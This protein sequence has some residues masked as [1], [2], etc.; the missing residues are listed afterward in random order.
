M[1]P[2]TRED[3]IE[4]SKIFKEPPMTKHL[5]PRIWVSSNDNYYGL[6]QVDAKSNVEKIA[7]G[8]SRYDW[9]M[10]S[11]ADP[12]KAIGPDYRE[13]F[14]H[15]ATASFAKHFQEAREI[16]GNNEV[17]L[18]RRTVLVAELL[19]RLYASI[20]ERHKQFGRLEAI[21]DIVG[22]RPGE[23]IEVTVKNLA[24]TECRLRLELMDE[25]REKLRLKMEIGH[26]VAAMSRELRNLRASNKAFVAANEEQAKNIRRL[27][28]MNTNQAATIRAVMDN[29]DKFR[30]ETR[31]IRIEDYVKEMSE[32]SVGFQTTIQ[33]LL[34]EN[35]RLCT[36]HESTERK[37]RALKTALGTHGCDNSL[38]EFER[39]KKNAFC[40][41]VVEDIDAIRKALGINTISDAVVAINELKS[42]Q[43]GPATN[44]LIDRIRKATDST[45]FIL[46]V[47][48][49]EALAASDAAIRSI[50]L[51]TVGI[52]Q[53]TSDTTEGL[54]LAMRK[55]VE[56]QVA[57][58]DAI[59]NRLGCATESH[60]AT[61]RK[62]EDLK[63]NQCDWKWGDT[64]LR[65]KS[66]VG[67]EKFA[68]APAAVENL[69]SQN[70]RLSS[71]LSDIYTR[72][73]RPVINVSTPGI[74]HA[75]SPTN[76]DLQQ[77]IEKVEG[78]LRELR[79][80]VDGRQV[81][82]FRDCC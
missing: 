50:A 64:C 57:K 71:Q 33:G 28:E 78:Q 29:A 61:V 4:L 16:V 41:R 54:V 44:A 77:R 24:D 32:R 20:D 80:T 82:P 9:I 31:S 69:L 30:S 23:T 66:L 11:F 75:Q 18:D 10:N 67:V 39:L 55:E 59:K 26:H 34:T 13:S 74:L 56:E 60:Q 12:D 43:V 8:H 36:A 37:Y 2:L 14:D 17:N 63:E 27:D 76:Q 70:K 48:R 47:P 6:R 42:L 49:V 1:K 46:A 62:I 52:L 38:K 53:C 7:N 79:R 45:N 3:I 40:D 22:T 35:A 58:L 5:Y 81:D 21:S 73:S 72:G 19:G 65:I 68:D 15:H 25:A 51:N